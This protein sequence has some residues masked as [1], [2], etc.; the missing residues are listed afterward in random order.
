MS[1]ILCIA[2][3][4]WLDM[5]RRKDA[6]V[7][8]ILL[9]ALLV[10]LA[11]L[12]IFGLGGLTVYVKDVG[13]LAT[14][15]FGWILG[16]HVAC[17]GL[18]Q[19]E[20]RGTVYALLAKPVTRGQLVVGKWLG[21]WS[22]TMAATVAF[23]ALVAA[24][25]LLRGGMAALGGPALFQGMLL[26]GV[27]L[28]MLCALGLLCSTRLHQDAAAALTY[29][30][31]AGAFVLLPRLPGLLAQARGAQGIL[32]SFVYHVLPHFQ[33][34]DMRKRI[35]HN[36]GPTDTPA[37][38]QVALYGAVYT[39]FLLVAAWLAYRNKRFGRENLL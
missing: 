19:E 32:L 22:V 39:A 5:L 23:Y 21:A 26:H 33:L 34:F 12:N 14:W 4:A 8:L 9:G 10:A 31:S 28:A 35:V 2:R 38:L 27:A 3:I 15:L 36:W 20:Q 6:Y 17:R 25:V 11:S 13:L 18:P 16:A 7:L 24:I 37:L 29:V 30:L 1:K